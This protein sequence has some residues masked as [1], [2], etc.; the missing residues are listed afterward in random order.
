MFSELKEKR[1]KRYCRECDSKINGI[2]AFCR[3]KCENDWI[4]R[5]KDYK[6]AELCCYSGCRSG[7]APSLGARYCSEFCYIEQNKI[8]IEKE[9]MLLRRINKII[10]KVEKITFISDLLE[11][12][13]LDSSEMDSFMYANEEEQQE[14]IRII[15]NG[16]ICARIELAKNEIIQLVFNSPIYTGP[17]G[18][19]SDLFGGDLLY[20]STNSTNSK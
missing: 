2:T 18:Q 13:K 5:N 15:K 6:P 8:D 10:K 4:D 1:I 12:S 20:E 7:L 14:M 11:L 16:E 19:A 17:I 9:K 3:K